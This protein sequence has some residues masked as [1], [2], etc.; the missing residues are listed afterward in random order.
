MHWFLFFVYLLVGVDA[1]MMKEDL[2][3]RSQI[4]K[5]GVVRVTPEELDTIFDG[6]GMRDYFLVTLI[7]STNPDAECVLCKKVQPSFDEV[8]DTVRTKEPNAPVFFAQ[9]DVVNNLA[10]V[11][12]A[13]IKS[14]PQLFIYPPFEMLYK[15]SNED[16]LDTRIPFPSNV[17]MASE[18]YQ[19]PASDKMTADEIELHWARFVAQVC[20]V[21]VNIDKPFQTWTIIK[22]FIAFTV[23]FKIIRRNKMAVR[24]MF[25]EPRFYC[26]LSM[27]LIY[28]NMSGLNWCLQRA[29]PFLMRSEKGTLTWFTGNIKYQEGMESVLSVLFQLGFSALFIVLM[30]SPLYLEG[31]NRGAAVLVATIALFL[32]YNTFTTCWMAK[33]RSYPFNAVKLFD[34]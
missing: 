19:F 28:T 26:G 15:Y 25:F 21:N 13:N 5:N 30:E 22:S 20:N 33:D 18:H 14:V 6:T 27:L 4:S 12:A 29:V 10:K 16:P 17:S 32:L 34:I 31:G 9:V 23:I 1:A 24:G 7:T 8:A 11:K 2:R 3:A